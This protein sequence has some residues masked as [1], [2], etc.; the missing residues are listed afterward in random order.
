MEQ[1]QVGWTIERLRKLRV[2][3]ANGETQL[4]D[5]EERRARLRDS[6]LRIGGAIQ[7]LEELIEHSG[8]FSDEAVTTNGEA[9]LR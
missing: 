7:V 3:Y 5:L 6:M 9:K 2:E 8:A 1:E 4:Q